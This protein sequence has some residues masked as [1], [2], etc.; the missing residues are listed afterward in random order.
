MQHMLR[1]FCTWH[2]IVDVSLPSLSMC[3]YR[4]GA[5][6][7]WALPTCLSSW[8]IRDAASRDPTSSTYSRCRCWSTLSE[9]YSRHCVTTD[10]CSRQQCFHSSNDSSSSATDDVTPRGFGNDAQVTTA[11]KPCEWTH[12]TLPQTTSLQLQVVLQR[13]AETILL[14]HTLIILHL[15]VIGQSELHPISIHRFIYG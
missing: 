15:L 12:V 9:C 11:R 13:Q 7:R 4:G 6:A 8:R 1:N 14:T 5:A 3:Y 10:D 2:W